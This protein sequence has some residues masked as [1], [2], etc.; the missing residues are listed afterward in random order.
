MQVLKAAS[1]ARI[2]VSIK[3]ALLKAAVPMAICSSAA[4]AQGWYMGAGTGPSKANNLGNCSNLSGLLDPGFACD[5]GDLSFG[6]KL[7]AGYEITR[8]LAVEGSYVDLGEFTVSASGNAFGAPPGNTVTAS[9]R[10]RPTGFGLDAVGTWPVTEQVGV[11]GRVGIFAWTLD[12]SA[13]TSRKFIG[14]VSETDKPTGTGFD[15]GVGGKYDVDKNLGIRAEI[16]K[17]ASIGNG[18][19]GKSDVYLISASVV[20]RLRSSFY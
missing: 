11:I 7:F 8:N 9:V 14:S 5:S 10:D 6:W 16:Q 20:Y 13:N 12:A 15:F 19:T 3:G 4:Y 18:T 2:L 17:F 1:W